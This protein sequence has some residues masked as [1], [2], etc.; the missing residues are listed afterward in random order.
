MPV[1]EA[2]V[3]GIICG[4]AVKGREFSDKICVTGRWQLGWKS[5]DRTSGPGGSLLDEDSGLS[6]RFIPSFKNSRTRGKSAR[7]YWYTRRKCDWGPKGIRRVLPGSLILTAN[8]IGMMF[9]HWTC[10]RNPLDRDFGDL[11]VKEDVRAINDITVSERKAHIHHTLMKQGKP[12]C[13]FF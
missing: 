6:K 2:Y 10:F 3:D 7:A 13:S 11:K 8:A 12:S 4:A 9:V 1:G 5:I